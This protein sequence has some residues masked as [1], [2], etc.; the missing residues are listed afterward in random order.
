MVDFAGLKVA[1]FESRMAEDMTRLI[2]RYGG[3]PYVAPSLRET[4]LEDHHPIFAFA[5]RLL[6]GELDMV[7]FLT[8]VGVRYLME[9]LESRENLQAVNGALSR[10]TL[11]A[12][13]PKPIA[14]LKEFGLAATV[15]VPEPNTWRD[16]LEALD[17]AKKSL[18]GLR[19]AVQ[20]YGAS[21]RDLL[22]ALRERGAKVMPVPVYRWSLPED[23][24]P[25]RD[26]LGK[27]CAGGTD[28]LL[29]TNAAQVENVMTLLDQMGETASFRRAL[30]RMAV[31]SIG[32]TA[33]EHLHQHDLPVD[34]EPSHP[35]MGHLV[36]EMSERAQTILVAKRS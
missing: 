14:A 3:E 28:V 26:L 8:G 24:G 17:T 30:A 9:V 6:A 4:P 22:Q 35:K 31:G 33:T 18:R 10:I 7:I 27:V 34:L 29:I 25:L 15:C 16:L 19:I 5:A 2:R 23:P 12:R 20:E 21:N 13:G 1:A 11:V 32:P 36:K